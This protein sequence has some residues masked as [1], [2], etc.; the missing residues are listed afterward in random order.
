MNDPKMPRFSPELPRMII[1]TIVYVGMGIWG[2]NVVSGR[3]ILECDRLSGVVQCHLITKQLLTS[4]RVTAFE[5]AK[6]QK[7]IVGERQVSRRITNYLTIYTIDL[8]TDQGTFSLTTNQM[9]HAEKYRLVA[10]IN[11]F[12][13]NPQISTL[14]VEE[15]YSNL[16]WIGIGI[17][18]FILALLGFGWV[19]SCRFPA[20]IAAKTV[21][22]ILQ[23][24]WEATVA[25]SESHHQQEHKTS[26]YS[27]AK[28]APKLK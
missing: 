18:S 23:E 27:N 6:L 21:N 22:E 24:S 19:M 12:L 4:E 8:V 2:V 28:K 10:S 26:T 14:K 9:A 15:S 7:A 25:A 5:Q 13:E 1:T 16:F 17:F 20:D 3:R 11:A